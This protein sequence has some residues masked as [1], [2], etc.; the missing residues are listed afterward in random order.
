MGTGRVVREYLIP[1]RLLDL[2][3]RAAGIGDN[4]PQAVLCYQ[5]DPRRARDIGGAIGV[6]IDAEGLT[7]FLESFAASQ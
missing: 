2:A 5:L 3:R 6:D 7:F 4:D 1:D